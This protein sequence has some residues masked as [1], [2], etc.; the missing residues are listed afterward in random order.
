MTMMNVTELTMTQQVS[1]ELIFQELQKKFKKDENLVFS[2]S[3]INEIIDNIQDLTTV[4]RNSLKFKFRPLEYSHFFEEKYQRNV[5]ELIRRGYV[6]AINVENFDSFGKGAFQFPEVTLNI[7]LREVVQ[8]RRSGR[9]RPV[10]VVLDE[11]SRFIG[12]RKSGSLKESILESVDLDTRYNVNY[13][14][15]SQI[16]EDV[17]DT[18]LKQSKYI[19]IPATADVSTIKF[20]LINTG[21]AKNIQTAVNESMKL[22]RMMKQV[23]Y[24]WIVINRMTGTMDLVQPL[25]PLSWHL[26]TSN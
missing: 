24:S 19:F 21:M 16:I 7:V 3:L 8:A 14:F 10:W 2:V 6:P 20:T 13:I 1:F 26:T 17:P 18:V 5:V 25:P 12:S 23:K 9:I 15:A 22:K 11:A 4:Q